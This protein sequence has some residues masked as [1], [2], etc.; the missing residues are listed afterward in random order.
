MFGF[1]TD[2]DDRDYDNH[3]SFY[4]CYEEDLRLVTNLQKPIDDLKSRSNKF[5]FFNTELL[6]SEISLFSTFEVK[7]FDCL[8]LTEHLH[9]LQK[10]T[11]NFLYESSYI[12]MQNKT[13]FIK[14]GA[15]VIARLTSIVV[16]VSE[17]NAALVILRAL[18]SG[19]TEDIYMHRDMPYQD[20]I[21]K[22]DN[23]YFVIF[24]LKG[25]STLYFS[26]N[27]FENKRFDELAIDDGRSFGY[28]VQSLKKEK[29]YEFNVSNYVFPNYGFGSVHSVGKYEGA[30][31]AAPQANTTRLVL[32]VFPRGEHVLD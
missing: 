5:A 16:G 8:V 24:T 19:F 13:T 32:L 10:E 23:G 9:T 11:E 26:L 20:N 28:H 22:S 29:T 1:N 30:I 18:P 4:K 21:N 25:D 14:E 12:D 6:D 15:R 2:Y 7:D 27:E 31:H 3:D 17:Y